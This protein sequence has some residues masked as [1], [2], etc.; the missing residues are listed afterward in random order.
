[1]E[2]HS[3]V[4]ATCLL[5]SIVPA[6]AYADFFADSKASVELRNFYINR[7]YSQAS[8]T[9]S[10]QEEWA[11]GFLLRYAS[12][13]TAGPVGFGLDAIGLVGVKL[14]SS[15]DR[16]GSGLL[17]RQRDGRAVDERGSLGLTAKVRASKSLL[18]IGTL[19]P[20]LP[21]VQF[22]DTRL[23]PQT[24]EGV[25]LNS[26]EFANTTLDAGQIRQV[27]QRDSTN[28]EDLTP[29]VANAKGIR[30]S[31]GASTDEFNF[32]GV[33]YKWS[34]QLSGS[35]FY[36]E[37]DRFYR[38]HNFSLLHVLP[39]GEGQS[40]KSDLRYARSYNEG[41]SNIDN[42]AVSAM[43]TYSLGGHAFGLAYQKMSGDTGYAYIHGAD[44]FL[45]NFISNN[46][47]AN[48]DEMSWQARYDFNF[49]A[50]GIPGLTFMTRYVY[51]SDIELGAGKPTCSEWE[52]DT[53]IAYVFQDGSLKNL[54]VKW[55][56]S[57]LRMNHFGSDLDDNRLIISYTLPL[58]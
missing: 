20:R 4:I 21:V 47:F 27:T 57:S 53:D 34:N 52:R 46:D 5:V 50:V 58:L 38:Q 48:R 7:D 42:T 12:G 1:M 11:Q 36:G 19:H 39:L 31:K 40:L 51:G 45:P 2:R 32:A 44:A 17:P 15:Q 37:L 25:H 43:L 26:Q 10:K 14:D 28:R 56:N 33:G 3:C 13:F 23:L 55:R 41:Q 35:Y 9:Q 18:R 49:A 29:S 6:S 24:F 30:V 54:G 8:T 22:N 16:A